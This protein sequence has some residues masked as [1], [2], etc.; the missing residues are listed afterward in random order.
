MLTNIGHEGL[1]LILHDLAPK[2][3]R[4]KKQQ[5]GDMISKQQKDQLIYI[6]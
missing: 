6:N 3:H 5:I 2:V 4:I 1:G